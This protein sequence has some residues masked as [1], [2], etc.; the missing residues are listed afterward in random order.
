M[1]ACAVQLKM[2]HKIQRYKYLDELTMLDFS[3][4]IVL[5]CFRY[6]QFWLQ[7]TEIGLI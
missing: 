1:P 3:N 7:C 2:S 4:Q 5:Y 6:T